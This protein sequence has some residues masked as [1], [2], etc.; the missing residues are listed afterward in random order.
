MDWSKWASSLQGKANADLSNCT[1]PYVIE[2]SDKSL[3]PSWYRVW[4]DGWC[5]Q[6]G[7]QSVAEAKSGYITLLKEYKNFNYTVTSAQGKP[8]STTPYSSY[9][10]CVSAYSTTQLYWD[11]Y[12]K[13]EQRNFYWETKGY[14]K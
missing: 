14:I 10:N 5:E 11:A 1:R 6:G 4:S 13:N 12:D 7:W 9:S 3:L 8:N 2:T